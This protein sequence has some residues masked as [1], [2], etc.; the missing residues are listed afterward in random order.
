[1][2]QTQQ[3]QIGSPRA[4]A[5]ISGM[6]QRAR[7]LMAMLQHECS[8]VA[9]CM[10]LPESKTGWR[11]EDGRTL[12]GQVEISDPPSPPQEGVKE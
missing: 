9:E 11:S 2:I 6:L 10:G 1:M 5:D 3:V 12:I 7:E 4:V 8:K